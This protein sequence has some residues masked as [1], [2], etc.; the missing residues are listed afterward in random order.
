VLSR[1][2]SLRSAPMLLRSDHGSESVGEAILTWL[3]ETG[4]DSTLIDPGK[5]R[6]NGTG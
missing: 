6:Q 2:V 5:P 3:G 4:I 1:L